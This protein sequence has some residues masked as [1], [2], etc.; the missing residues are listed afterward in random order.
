MA[1]V[2][3]YADAVHAALRPDGGIQFAEGLVAKGLKDK[4]R[5]ALASQPPER[6]HSVGDWIA[7]A[8]RQ[9]PWDTER[10]VQFEVSFVTE[11]GELTLDTAYHPSYANAC[12]FTHWRPVG[13]HPAKQHSNRESQPARALYE[14]HCT[15]TGITPRWDSLD[16]H[17][18]GAWENRAEG[19]R[20]G[21]G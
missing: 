3:D 20:G 9:P 10:R 18:Q 4:L 15:R 14:S 2:D 21:N 6:V 5:A 17:Q 19:H 16:S 1:L 11:K 12:R 8:D 7:F 13:P